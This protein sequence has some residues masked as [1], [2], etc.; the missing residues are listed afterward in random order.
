MLTNYNHWALN[1]PSLEDAWIYSWLIFK[2]FQ[3]YMRSCV[4]FVRS[5]LGQ[6]K[7]MP[8]EQ[9]LEFFQSLQDSVRLFSSAS[10]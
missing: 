9:I 8:H 5:R 3:E 4:H 6:N 7:Y 2:G 10:C 1:V